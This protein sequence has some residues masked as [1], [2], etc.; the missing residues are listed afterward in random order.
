MISFELILPN[1]KDAAVLCAWRNDPLAL[2]M[3][4]THTKPKSAAEFFPDMMRRYF[5][6]PRLPPLFAVANGERVGALRFDPADDRFFSACEISLIVAPKLRGR[7]LGT[8][9][10]KGIEPFLRRQGIDRILARIKKENFASIK[11]FSRAEYQ[12]IQGGSILLFEKRLQQSAS[13][14]VF[15]IAEAGSNWKTDGEGKSLERAL[16]MIDSAKEAGAD[17]VKFQMFRSKD[18][19]VAHAGVSDYLAANGIR[20]DISELMR[21]LEMSEKMIGQLA[22]YCREAGIE[23]MTSVF[24]ERDF[25]LI[26]PLVKRHKMASYEIS[27]LRLLECAA[28]SGKPL[29]LSTGASSVSDID[30]AVDQFY[31]NGGKK[32]TLMQCTAKYPAPPSSINLRVI[33]W[34][35]SR[36]QTPA[37][38][39][40]HSRDPLIAPLGAVALGAAVIEKH[41]TLDRNFPGP[42]HSYAIEP[43]ELKQMI[44]A[45]R[46]MEKMKGSSL[47]EIQREE[48]ELYFFARRGI[49]ALRDIQSGEI[50]VEGENV[51]I[52]RPGKHRL[53]LHPR[54]LEV[55]AGKAAIRPI[56]QGVG[57]QLQDIE[58]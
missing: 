29:I 8:E 27:H 39:S 12:M 37:G 54:Y 13:D 14:K 3:S 23:F 18:T 38:L 26:D 51:A 5:S 22:A 41:F 49:Q 58:Q 4:L 15:I 48:E 20:Q 47:K 28:R 24:S 43:V 16:F 35:K 44:S 42:D 17:A 46:T 56:A 19:Y 45:I 7:G 40:D 11:V 52:L 32:L 34:I 9:I 50:L 33:P 21:S 36:Y 2:E 25:A 55:I 10:L 57:I 31:L 6:Y 1:E 53:G 30:W